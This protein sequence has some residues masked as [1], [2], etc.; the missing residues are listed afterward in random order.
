MASLYTDDNLQYGLK[1]S[2][3]NPIVINSQNLFL[4]ENWIELH[5]HR[6]DENDPRMIAV[7]PNNAGVLIDMS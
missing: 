6:A 7:S 2:K 3:F 5:V 4:P 1:R